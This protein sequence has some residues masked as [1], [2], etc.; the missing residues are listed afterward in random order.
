MVRW[1]Q[2]VYLRRCL[3]TTLLTIAEVL[4]GEALVS[5]GGPVDRVTAVGSDAQLWGL[6]EVA[7]AATVAVE[8]PVS[9][10]V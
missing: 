2:A 7:E 5:P 10:L 4:A 1:R 9:L 3:M 8:A 6:L